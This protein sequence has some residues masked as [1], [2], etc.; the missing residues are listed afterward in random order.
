MKPVWEAED[1]I[2]P[3]VYRRLVRI[4][5]Y[6]HNMQAKGVI[7]INDISRTF[8]TDSRPD[9]DSEADHQQRGLEEGCV[10]LNCTTVSE[11]AS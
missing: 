10:E 6:S 8:L 3:Q 5:E 2:L 1:C 4:Q 11:E 9:P 7:K